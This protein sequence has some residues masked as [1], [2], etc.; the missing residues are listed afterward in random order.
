MVINKAVCI[1]MKNVTRICL[2]QGLEGARC[3]GMIDNK[4]THAE[5]R[6][7]DRTEGAQAVHLFY[8]QR[9]IR[10]RFRRSMS[11]NDDITLW[12]RSILMAGKPSLIALN[13]M[14]QQHPNQTTVCQS[15]S[16]I[17]KNEHRNHLFQGS[18]SSLKYDGCSLS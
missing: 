5:I 17:M 4:P 13:T 1:L 15:E 8:E 11:F 7:T 14:D 6:L 18:V 12:F 2:W 10:N 3:P 9:K 16:V